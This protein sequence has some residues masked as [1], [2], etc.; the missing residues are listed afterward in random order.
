MAFT[1]KKI[2]GDMAIGGS[3][4]DE[5]GAKTVKDLMA[6]AEAANV[7]I[8]L[9]TDFVCGV[10]AAPT[11]RGCKT[12]RSRPMLP[13]PAGNQFSA[14][15]EVKNVTEAE[16]VPEGWLG[17]DVGPASAEAFADAVRSAGTVVWNGPMG[18]FEF[19]N[20]GALLLVL[21]VATCQSRLTVRANCLA[22]AANGTKAVMDAVVQATEAGSM[23][24]IGGGDTATCAKDFGTEDK[25]RRQQRVPLLRGLTPTVPAGEPRQHRRR[26]VPGAA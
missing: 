9:P 12:V 16:G 4:F 20:F 10:P 7:K 14:D 5:E 26:R 15:A 21:P 3:L 19:P 18:V 1:F 8:L 17:L 13:S 24:I 25:V 6:K 23:T 2:L 11:P 22:D